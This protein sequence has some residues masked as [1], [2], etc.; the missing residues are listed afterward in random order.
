MHNEAIEARIKAARGMA[1][2]FANVTPDNLAWAEDGSMMVTWSDGADSRYSRGYLRAICPCAECRG[3]HGGPP[4]AFNVLSSSQVRGAARQTV[5]EAVDP[6]GHYALVFTW[7]DGH[8]DGIYSW[9]Y[10]RAM[11]PELSV[12][13]RVSGD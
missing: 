12:Q 3:T 9:P 11:D 5:I 1:D 7:G 6:A 4:K 13:G 8:K 2:L 10:L